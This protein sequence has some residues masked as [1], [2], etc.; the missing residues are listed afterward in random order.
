M[1]SLT[2]SPTTQFGWNGKVYDIDLAFDTVL[3]YLQLQQDSKVSAFG[4]WR[5][6]CKLFFWTSKIAG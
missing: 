2:R 6:S 5:Q 3:L 1:L 4:K